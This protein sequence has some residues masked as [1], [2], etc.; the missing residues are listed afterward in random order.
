MR[1]EARSLR[2]AES[3]LS[4]CVSLCKHS[5]LYQFLYLTLSKYG[6]IK[7]TYY[8]I[9]HTDKQREDEV[10]NNTWRFRRNKKAI[11]MFYTYY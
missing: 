5:N 10:K 2:R 8:I 4:Q 9:R 7:Q 1:P 6:V 3:N 11:E